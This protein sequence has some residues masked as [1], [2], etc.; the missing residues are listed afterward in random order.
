MVVLSV[1]APR[2]VARLPDLIIQ[3]LPRCTVFGTNGD[4]VLTGTGGD[5]VICARAG[6]DVVRGRG[7]DDVLFG[8]PG[9]DRLEGGRGDDDLRGVWGADRLEGGPGDD[10]LQGGL[11]PDR[12]SGGSGRDLA[13]YSVRRR[14]VRV[15]IGG[16]SDGL[17]DEGDD[18]RPDVERLRGGD[19]DDRLRGNGDAN[20]LAGGPGDDEL[21]GRGGQD[22]LD[23]GSGGDELDGRGGRDELDG[24]RGADRLAGGDGDDRLEGGPG[25][26]RMS[27]GDGDDRLDGRDSS[28]FV[29][30][31][32]CGRGDDRA[33]ADARDRV[34]ADCEEGETSPSPGPPPPGPPTPAPSPPGPP[35]PGPPPPNS[36]PTAIVL[37]GNS[38]AENEPAG[39]EVGALRATDADVADVHTFTLVS[40]DGDDDNVAFAIVGATLQTAAVLDFEDQA[41]YSIR[42]RADDGRGGVVEQVLTITVTDTN[43]PPTVTTSGGA[44]GYSE[45]AP[46]VLVDSG[47]L[48]ADV[49]DVSLVGATVRVSAAF[50]PGDELLF[51]DQNG[52]AGSFDGG[53]GV[54]TLTGTASLANYQAA[55]RSVQF[56]TSNDDPVSVKTVEFRADDGDGLGP[57]AT[58]D[59]D[60]TAVNDAPT[61]ETSAGSAAFVEGAGPVVVD[62]DVVVSDPDSA[63]L[64]GAT[65]ELTSNFSAGDS[66]GFSD[67]NGITGSYDAGTGVLT[68]SG[69]ASVAD[70]QAALRTVT[71]DNGSSDPSTATR[72]VEFQVTDAGG[73]ASNVATRAVTVA[74]ANNAPTV[75]TSAGALSYSEGDAAIAVDSGVTV[76]DLDDSDLASATVR[77]SAGFE[78][79]DELLFSDQNGITGSYDAG[80]GVLALTGTSSLANYQTALR[81]VRYRHTD[82][83]PVASKTIEFVVSDGTDDSVPATRAITVTAVNDAPI[84]TTS[85]AALAYPENAGPVAADAG[86]TVTDPDSIQISGRHGADHGELRP[87]A[88]R[89]RVRRPVRHQR[90][91]RR[92]DRD[93]D[94]D[95]HGL[96][97]GVPG[98]AAGRHLRERL[99]QPVAGDADAE[100]RRHRCRRCHQCAGDARDHF[101]RQQRR[102]DDHDDRHAAGVHRGRSGAR[103]RQRPDRPGP[104]RR[105]SRGRDR[106]DLGRL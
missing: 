2:A 29:D 22:R 38:V 64:F 10:E 57:A 84:L 94:A 20:G 105:R 46:A 82:E 26:D 48:V 24:G 66:L 102:R 6:D 77:V 100:L 97:R 61:V 18:V 89:A 106:A 103:G 85:A 96:G 41:T 68:L 43:E 32:R 4:D 56:R 76:A 12:M 87:R 1:M 15:T 81:S 65:V 49:D 36:P 99:Q 58:R 101:G 21:D 42:V 28:G 95:R 59:I 37:T 73:L 71:Y 33:L 53:T 47:L 104:R 8:G 39:T 34:A 35:P 30:N 90:V 88:G 11:G 40:G 54:L 75:T 52:I 50:Q 17:P 5:D 3:P 19:G 13:D 74:A 80:T 14:A 25:D 98:R 16:G 9:R 23:G 67:Q 72:T 45:G 63:T 55:L 51:S 91:L 86:I 70:Y 78:S 60:V 69:A 44:V 7:G 31:L 62:A 92:H 27:G 79:G 93:A 83:N